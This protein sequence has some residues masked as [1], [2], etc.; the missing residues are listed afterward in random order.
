MCTFKDLAFFGVVVEFEMED[1][2]Q[3]GGWHLPDMK[4]NPTTTQCY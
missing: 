2:E 4:E 1:K 3:K